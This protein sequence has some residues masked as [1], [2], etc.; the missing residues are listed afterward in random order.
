MGI[1]TKSTEAAQTAVTKAEAVVA[2]WERKAADARSEAARLDREAGAAILADE[3]A[4]ERITLSIQAEERKARAYDQAA[5]EA[6][7]KLLAAQREALESEAREEDKQ[8]AVARKTA[9]AHSLK[10]A[11]LLADLKRIDGCDYTPSSA[12]DDYGSALGLRQNPKSTGLWRTVRVHETHAAAIRYFIST[13]TV[14]KDYYELNDTLKT[15]FEGALDSL[16]EI[17]LPASIL[18]A[19]DAGLN[20]AGVTV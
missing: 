16:N 15:P 7:R 8:A 6:R 5:A 19:R 14:P 17:G 18:A 2:D 4:A 13:G 1:F 12:T 9:D 3:S 20:F 11:S 10:V